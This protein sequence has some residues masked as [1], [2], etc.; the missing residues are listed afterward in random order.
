[1]SM[2]S[3]RRSSGQGYAPGVGQVAS[4]PSEQDSS[5]RRLQVRPEDRARPHGKRVSYT[6]GARGRPNCG[7]L[8]PRAVGRRPR[9]SSPQG[10]CPTRGRS[11]PSPGRPPLRVVRVRA[12]GRDAP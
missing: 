12:S 2:N 6:W 11:L 5:V 8:P 10:W 7:L 9:P 3:V 4:R 1:M